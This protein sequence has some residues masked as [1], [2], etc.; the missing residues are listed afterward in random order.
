[1]QTAASTEDAAAGKTEHREARQGQR[2]EGTEAMEGARMSEEF[3]VAFCFGEGLGPCVEANWP[4]ATRLG[5]CLCGQHLGPGW[6]TS[7]TRK[8]KAFAGNLLFP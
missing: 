6:E 8:L 2:A 7:N 5:L 4:I 3:W 1:M